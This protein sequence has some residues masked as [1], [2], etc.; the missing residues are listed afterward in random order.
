[1]IK[2]LEDPAMMEHLELEGN[3]QQ[4]DTDIMEGRCVIDNNVLYTCTCTAFAVLTFSFL[5]LICR[6]ESYYYVYQQLSSC[7]PGY[8]TQSSC[9]SYHQALYYQPPC[10]SC[11]SYQTYVYDNIKFI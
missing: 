3:K 1:M 10:H 6:L 7:H 5:L 8:Y 11:N 9:H 2:L 4:R